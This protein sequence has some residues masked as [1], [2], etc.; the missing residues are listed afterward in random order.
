MGTEAVRHTLSEVVRSEKGGLLGQL[1]EQ[2]SFHR[3]SS[4]REN[5]QPGETLTTVFRK[6]G[7]AVT[8]G[9]GPQSHRTCRTHYQT[10]A[11]SME[12]SGERR[13][14]PSQYEY[15]VT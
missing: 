12:D 13:C 3:T 5:G 11:T 10:G 8:Y 2:R 1:R 6:G 7:H 15:V 4:W 14:E 9:R